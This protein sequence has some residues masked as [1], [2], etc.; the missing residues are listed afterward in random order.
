MSQDIAKARI[1]KS[2]KG[3]EMHGSNPMI[4]DIFD[5]WKDIEDLLRRD[6]YS[7]EYIAAR[8]AELDSTHETTIDETD[9]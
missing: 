7:T 8:K 3:Y 4:I 1:S 2:D 9:E 5:E 6:D